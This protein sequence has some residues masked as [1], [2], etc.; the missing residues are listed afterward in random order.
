[1]P[2]KGEHAVTTIAYDHQIFSMQQFGG[3]SRYFGDSCPGW[4]A[5]R[6]DAGRDCPLHFNDYLANS[7]VRR[8]GGYLPRRVPHTGP[9]YRAVNAVVAPLLHLATG[10]DLLHHTYYSSR[11]RPR[12]AKVVVTV[13]DMIHEL[14][15]ALLFRA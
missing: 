2:S 13:F 6:L 14:F 5:R 12:G 11:P 4:A 15:A 10:A 7:P 3:V 8:L 1:M 9:L